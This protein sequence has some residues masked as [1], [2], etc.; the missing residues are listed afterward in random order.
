MEICVLVGERNRVRLVC[1]ECWASLTV[2]ELPYP[3]FL[4]A[5]MQE[6]C[7]A[8]NRVTLRNVAHMEQQSS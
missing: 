8:C 2:L 3:T 5:Q 7:R 1:L 4:M 6:G